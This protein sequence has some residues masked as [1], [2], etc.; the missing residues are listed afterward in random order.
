MLDQL[1]HL[2]T[3]WS[4]TNDRSLARL[5]TIVA[6][7]GGLFNRLARGGRLTTKTFEDFLRFF[8]D[9]GNWAGGVIP[10]AA[11]ELLDNFEN[12][13]TEAAAST[14]SVAADSSVASGEAARDAAPRL[15][16]DAA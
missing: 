5:A 12:I 13:A 2:S 14:V 10:D 8:R 6:N 15:A 4:K 16:R 9:G 1:V 7:E 11:V 3:I